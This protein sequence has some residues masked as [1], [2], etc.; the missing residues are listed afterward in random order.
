MARSHAPIRWRTRWLS[1]S[2]SRPSG[3]FACPDKLVFGLML[4]GRPPETPEQFCQQSL[5]DT[6]AGLTLT[7]PDAAADAFALARA[8]ETELVQSVEL[9]N[10]DGETELLKDEFK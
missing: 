4:D 7:A 10:W 1:L 2:G 3:G 5:L 6:Y 9:S 8:V